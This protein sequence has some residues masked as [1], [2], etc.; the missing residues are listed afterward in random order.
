MAKHHIGWSDKELCDTTTE[1]HRNVN[2]FDLRSDLIYVPPPDF[3]LGGIPLQFFPFTIGYMATVRVVYDEF[4]QGEWFSE[5][6]VGFAVWLWGS[7]D[8]PSRSDVK[9][10]YIFIST[11]P[12]WNQEATSETSAKLK[13]AIRVALDGAFDV[14]NGRKVTFSGN[15]T[16]RAKEEDGALD[17]RL[18][19]EAGL[20]ISIWGQL[21]RATPSF[22]FRRDQRPPPDAQQ[23]DY[24]F[25]LQVTLK[26]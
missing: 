11:V 3:R 19:L 10:D 6:G 18:L 22:V 7:P 13:T 23:N 5:G 25:S 24:E 14:L 4:K 26:P 12:T 2:Q 17:Y 20:D 8:D 21:V 9:D 15:F 16:P 1:H